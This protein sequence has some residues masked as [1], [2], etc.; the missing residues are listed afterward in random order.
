MTT[1]SH[2][3]LL[4]DTSTFSTEGVFHI[5]HHSIPALV[6][7]YGTP[8][9]NLVPRPAVLLVDEHIIHLMER[10]ETYQDLLSRYKLCRERYWQRRRI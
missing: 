9:Y 8:L 3:H 10:C 6:Q 7:Q 1:I 2:S 4:P 5:A